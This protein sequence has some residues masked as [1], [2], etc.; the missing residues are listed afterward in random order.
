MRINMSI[1]YELH[2]KYS[3]D[4]FTEESI[5]LIKEHDTDKPLFLYLAHAAV[6][7]GNPYEPLRAP[8]DEVEKFR[9]IQDPQRQKFAGN[10]A[11]IFPSGRVRLDVEG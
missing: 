6:H 7:S 10:N 11:L 9:Y 4:L 3:T 2:G 1:A 5:R 8:D